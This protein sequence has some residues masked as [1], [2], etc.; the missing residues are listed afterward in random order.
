MNLLC[1]ECVG[2]ALR[3]RSVGTRGVAAAL[4]HCGCCVGAAWR[5]QGG[6]QPACCGLKAV[7]RLCCSSD[8]GPCSLF[9]QLWSNVLWHLGKSLPFSR[10]F[11]KSGIL[12]DFGPCLEY[13]KCI[14][15][16]FLTYFRLSLWWSGISD[17]F[18]SSMRLLC[19]SSLCGLNLQSYCR[20]C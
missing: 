3:R 9:N 20:Y 8:C 2:S 19:A 1:G 16:L 14:N 15:Q 5:T 11:S 18:V 10:D 7:M 17:T 4:L 12:G 13:V 6:I